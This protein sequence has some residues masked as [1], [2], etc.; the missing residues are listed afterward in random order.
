M[1]SRTNAKFIVLVLIW[2]CGLTLLSLRFRSPYPLITETL[3][4]P[5]TNLTD[6]F[7]VAFGMRRLSADAAWVQLLQYYGTDEP[8]QS[9]ASSENGGGFYPKV[10]TY[11]KRVVQ[12]DPRFTYAYIYGASALGWNLNRLSEAVSLL[13]DGID[14]NPHEWRFHEY[15]AGLSYQKDH[16]IRQLTR[17]LEA[18]ATD[19]ETPNLLRALLANLYKKTGRYADAYRI[20]TIVSQT[21]SSGEISRAA[22]QMSQLRAL[23]R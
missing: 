11:C 9:E 3:N 6:F 2:L 21:G 12:L 10:F 7:G 8:G 4:N 20:W 23:I 13:E 15:L 19:P 14:R 1:E 16:D 18:T 5:Q 22:V 17:F